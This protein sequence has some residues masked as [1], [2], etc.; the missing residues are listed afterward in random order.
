MNRLLLVPPKEFLVK[1][2]FKLLQENDREEN[3]GGSNDEGARGD[4]GEWSGDVA[5]DCFDK[6]SACGF[7]KFDR[8]VLGD[9][10]DGR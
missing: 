9:V 5:F 10:L 2:M 1:D 4:P 3:E 6:E 8:S 7:G